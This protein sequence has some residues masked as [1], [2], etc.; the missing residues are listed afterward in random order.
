MS[1]NSEHWKRW[2]VIAFGQ[3]R[4]NSR[5]QFIFLVWPLNGVCLHQ[6]Q[7]LKKLRDFWG[8]NWNFWSLYDSFLVIWFLMVIMPQYLN[9]FMWRISKHTWWYSMHV[10]LGDRRSERKLFNHFN[11]FL[12]ILNCDLWTLRWNFCSV[13]FDDLR[14]VRNFLLSATIKWYRYM[15][16]RSVTVCWVVL[17]DFDT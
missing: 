3:L 7:K 12:C 16:V 13:F 11:P 1:L 6:V 14:L 9:L 8:I 17:W 4:T 5:E 2:F 10:W 15:Y